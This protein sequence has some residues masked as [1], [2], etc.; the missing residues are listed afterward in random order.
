MLDRAGPAT[1]CRDT[2]GSPVS[3]APEKPTGFDN[4]IPA[5]V[6]LWV[7]AECWAGLW[8]EGLV[9]AGC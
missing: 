5:G 4:R 6:S 3:D 1:A 2:G 9:C 8:V 7:P